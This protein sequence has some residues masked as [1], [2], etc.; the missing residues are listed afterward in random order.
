MRPEALIFYVP[1][2]EN[3]EEA[4]YLKELITVTESH[5]KAL[6]PTYELGSVRVFIVFESPKSIFRIQEMA[7]ALE[8]H[9]WGVSGLA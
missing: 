4:A 8:P 5:I 2:L 1:K 3:E 6:H 9:F 7:H